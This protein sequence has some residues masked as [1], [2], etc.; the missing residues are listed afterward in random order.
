MMANSQEDGCLEVDMD[1]ESTQG[2]HYVCLA[3]NKFGLA[4]I[5]ALVYARSFGITLSVLHLLWSVKY[6]CRE[7]FCLIFLIVQIELY[8]DSA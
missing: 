4:Q 7:S 8:D 2:T 6:I 1:R 5:G 3:K